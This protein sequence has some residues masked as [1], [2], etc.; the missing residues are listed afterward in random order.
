VVNEN[1]DWNAAGLRCRS[2]HTDAHLLVIND[3]VEQS[4]VAGMLSSITSKFMFF[5]LY[6]NCYRVS[7]CENRQIKAFIGL[8]RRAIMVGGDVHEQCNGRYFALLHRIR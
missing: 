4:A 1:L 5:S 7:L 6:V 8:S 3:A 2:L